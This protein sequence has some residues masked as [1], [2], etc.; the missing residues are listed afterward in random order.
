MK[1]SGYRRYRRPASRE[2]ASVK[3]DNRQEQK[4]FGETT[5]E[6]FFKPV[7]L[8]PQSAGVREKSAERDKEEKVQ[9]TPEKKEEDKKSNEKRR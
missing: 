5:Q 2:T 6:N 1:H 3:K 4:F 7:A 9:R 8:T